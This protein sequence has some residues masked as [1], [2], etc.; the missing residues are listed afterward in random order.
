M[1]RLFRAG[2]S[3]KRGGTE[4]EAHDTGAGTIGRSR[5]KTMTGTEQDERIL[6]WI[7]VSLGYRLECRWL[8]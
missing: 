1:E 3:Q 2:A 6:R 5:E 8:D 7:A 4:A